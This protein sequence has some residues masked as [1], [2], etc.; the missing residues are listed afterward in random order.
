MAKIM[1]S[2]LSEA[3]RV[4]YGMPDPL[5]LLQVLTLLQSWQDIRVALD[6]RQ[7]LENRCRALPKWTDTFAGLRVSK[8]KVSSFEIDGVFSQGQDFT[9]AASRES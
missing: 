1:Y 5:D 8:A 6:R 9:F 3:G 2:Q 4:P 7:G